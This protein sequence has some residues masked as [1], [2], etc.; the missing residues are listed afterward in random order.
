MNDE[1]DPG[2]NDPWIEVG[3]YQQ[4][5][6]CHERAIVLEALG[7]D[8]RIVHEDN[9]Y[10]LLVPPRDAPKAESEL[11][12][13]DAENEERSRP[14]DVPPR[15]SNGISATVG[16]CIILILVYFFE[17]RHVFAL[18]WW[19]AGK[20]HAW[21]I[22]GGEWWRAV[23]ALSLHAD[24]PHLLGNIAFGSL[25][26]V[27][28]CYELGTGLAWFSILL[29]GAVGNTL[30]ALLQP[31]THTS[32]GASTAVFGALGVLVTLQ[33]RR[34]SQLKR[35]RLRRLAPL[36]MGVIFLG[37]LGT[38]GE[39]TDVLAH[40]LGITAGGL[41]GILLENLT[42]RIQLTPRQQT[43]LAWMMPLFLAISW[44]LAFTA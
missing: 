11:V 9:F 23:T 35:N 29:A 15:I 1:F 38:S 28:L 18:D 10:R 3:G 7:I 27:F 44:I 39:R 41:L 25:F 8:Y 33:W 20:T 37:F 14:D 17:K 4:P 2:V 22:R 36:I 43:T 5:G 34:R 16:Y 40:V 30:N 12:E 32:V 26:G 42:R 31:P 6:D 13:Y 19:D 21:L 24:P